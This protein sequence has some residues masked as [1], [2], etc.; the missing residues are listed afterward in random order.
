[1]ISEAI[2]S[3]DKRYRYQLKRLWDITLPSILFI[4]LNPSPANAKKNDPTLRR[5]IGFT[6]AWGYGGF[7]LCNLYAFCTPSP[8]ELFRQIDPI[9]KGN[10]RWIK[11]S[12]NDVDRVVLMYG[13]HGLKNNRAQKVIQQFINPYCIAISKRNMP[14][15][16][17]YLSYTKKPL[18]YR[19]NY[20]C[21]KAK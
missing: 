16:P 4:G 14:K 7:I 19:E 11:K 8:A 5:L 2:F 21:A 3:N 13:N 20:G 17:L 6:K 9:G 12:A 10:D 15:H 1:M 18:V